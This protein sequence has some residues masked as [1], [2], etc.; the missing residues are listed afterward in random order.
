[1]HLN[2]FC[3]FDVPF[4]AYGALSRALM[5]SVY[6]DNAVRLQDMTLMPCCR[7][8]FSLPAEVFGSNNTEK[9]TQCI[10]DRSCTLVL[11]P[12]AR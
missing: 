8:C 1:M 6:G 9:L 5:M 10:L 7:A 12:C 3:Y 11:F 4:L 2:C